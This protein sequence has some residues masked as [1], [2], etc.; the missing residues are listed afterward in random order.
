MHVLRG[1]E[2]DRYERPVTHDRVE[3]LVDCAGDVWA[4][5]VRT[6]KSSGRDSV[7]TSGWMAGAVV[8]LASTRASPHLAKLCRVSS[9]QKGLATLCGLSL[10][11]VS[12]VAATW[13][14][15]SVSLSQTR[16][17]SRWSLQALSNEA[18]VK[19]FGQAAV[20][21]GQSQVSA[22]RRWW[23]GRP[24]ESVDRFMSTVSRLP[25]ENKLFFGTVVASVVTFRLVGGRFRGMC[26]SDLFHYGS[27]ARRSIP[28][29]SQAYATTTE[30]V[31]ITSLGRM[32]GCHT[33]G[34]QFG[35]EFIADHQP[36][37]KYAT[38]STKQVFLPHCVSCSQRQSTACAT[39]VRT[40]LTPYW[41][42][43]RLYHVWCPLPLWLALGT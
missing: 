37:N 9:N 1:C 40:L 10:V 33:C 29:P 36:P 30:R 26:A 31:A 43:F 41:L 2:E 23:S 27:Y 18:L 17:Q 12:S 35:T 5:T 4:A 19:Q 8:F 11:G 25:D 21:V 28:A 7:S 34:K 16:N 20:D 14:C 32:H 6:C 39:D 42:A 13:M 15:W 24:F 3:E 22:L 38:L